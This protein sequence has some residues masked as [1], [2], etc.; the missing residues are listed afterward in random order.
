M[1]LMRQFIRIG[2]V[3]S[4]LATM[5]SI[6]FGQ[7]VRMRIGLYYPLLKRSDV[8]KELK[9]SK[10]VETKVKKTLNS[11]E[12]KYG[13]SDD[14]T[15]VRTTSTGGDF[16]SAIES[17]IKK[18][19]FPLFKPAQLAR[20]EE[21]RIQTGG[22][23]MLSEKDIQDRL[24]MTKEQRNKVKAALNDCN[25][26]IQEFLMDARGRIDNALRT[27]IS[28]RYDKLDEEMKKVLTADQL[29]AFEK[30]KGVKMKA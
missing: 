30:M 5:T 18:Q 29:K 4:L 2:I 12:V 22:Y 21:I 7:S 16:S 1:L 28:N 24:K 11:L 3:L 25:E 8:I 23:R 9:L 26:E 10:D 17:E 27:K 19:I 6:G 13:I 20:L 14:G 15:G